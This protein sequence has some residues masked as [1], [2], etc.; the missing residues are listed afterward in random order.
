MRVLL[1]VMLPVFLVGG[2]G[3][4]LGR[5]T[6][7]D[8]TLLTRV[9]IYLFGPALI[10]R[11]FYTSSVAGGDALRIIAFVVSLQII[12]LTVSRLLGRVLG[13]DD[14]TKA[15]GSLM[16]TFA[17]C[18]NYGLPVLLFAYGEN[19]FALGVVYMLTGTFLHATLGVGIAS[20]HRGMDPRTW[21][22][23]AIRVPWLYAFLLAIVFRLLG[24]ELPVGI[25]RGVDLL[26]SAAIP[27]QLV[28]LGIQ[29]SRVGL[30]RIGGEAIWL[31]GL[32]LALPPL[33]GWGLAAVLGAHGVLRAVLI[34]QASMP[35]AVNALILSMHFRRRADLS[36]TVI[37]LTTLF[38]LGTVALVLWLLGP[39]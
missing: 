34:V 25:Y 26:A 37:L 28:I 23:R 20:W 39:A 7:L 6:S 8:A 13:W 36:A 10:F 16:M 31:T 30:K 4:A 29:L 32:K 3:A 2:A 24:W 17:N 1:E 27:V 35:S 21:L 15:A 22:G 18:G 11:S 14:D 38:S 33:I 9:A 19:G 12:L 5:L